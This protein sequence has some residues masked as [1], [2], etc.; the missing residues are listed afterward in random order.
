MNVSIRQI[1]IYVIRKL[2]D[3][4]KTAER[5]IVQFVELRR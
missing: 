3:G 1:I 4:I 5:D 2:T